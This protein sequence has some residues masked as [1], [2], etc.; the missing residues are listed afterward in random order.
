MLS[1]EEDILC[2]LSF[3]FKNFAD[4]FALLIEFV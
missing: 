2:E 1:P 3:E 4:D